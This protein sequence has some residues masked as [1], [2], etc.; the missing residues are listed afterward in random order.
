[1][2]SQLYPRINIFEISMIKGS[3]KIASNLFVSNTTCFPYLFERWIHR[4]EREKE[5][6][7]CFFFSSFPFFLLFEIETSSITFSLNANDKK[8]KKE[9]FYWIVFRCC[10]WQ[11]DIIIRVTSRGTASAIANANVQ[12][13]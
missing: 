8:G 13:D 2:N 6:S 3:R 9:E 12:F 1:M 5:I 11:N 4:K 10:P 7:T